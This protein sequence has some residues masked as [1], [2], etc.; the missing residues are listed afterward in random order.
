MSKSHKFI[1]ITEIHDFV[2]VCH[3]WKC[4]VSYDPNDS[5]PFSLAEGLPGVI[6]IHEPRG[7]IPTMKNY[8][9]RGRAGAPLGCLIALTHRLVILTRVIRTFMS[10]AT[11]MGKCWAEVMSCLYPGGPSVPPGLSRACT[12]QACQREWGQCPVPG[13]PVVRN[14]NC[15]HYRAVES[16][17][18]VTGLRLP[19]AER[20]DVSSPLHVV[21]RTGAKLRANGGIPT[22]ELSVVF[23]PPPLYHVFA[24]VYE[25]HA[26]TGL[27][28][29]K[30]LN[31]GTKMGFGVCVCA[32]CVISHNITSSCSPRLAW[33]SHFYV[34]VIPSL[35]RLMSLILLKPVKIFRS[36]SFPW[37]VFFTTSP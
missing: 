17:P 32:V 7:L 34:S 2:C 25:K 13:E 28:T 36:R 18:G 21:C 16:E 1:S 37:M 31:N 4:K 8:G 22:T 27:G 9:H 11:V 35:D 23:T 15:S 29:S 6:R 24:A 3:D 10:A 30:S 26:T 33:S 19:Q 14:E 5:R 12:H 20:S